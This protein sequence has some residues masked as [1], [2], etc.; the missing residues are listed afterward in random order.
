M[1]VSGSVIDFCESGKVSFRLLVRNGNFLPCW[2]TV[3][4]SKLIL[5][6]GFGKS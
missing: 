6:I 1:G 2:R 4:F 5:I 3:G